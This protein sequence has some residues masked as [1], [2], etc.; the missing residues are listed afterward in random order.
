MSEVY[1]GVVFRS[2]ERAARRTFGSLSSGL[3][4][5]LVRLA[6]G[7]FGA[8]RVAGRAGALDQPAVERVAQ[9]VSAAVGRAVA[10]FYDNRCG[11]RAGVL[12]C[13]GRRDRELGDDDTWWARCGRDGEPIPGGRRFRITDLRPGEEYECTYSAIDAGLEVV[14]VGPRVSAAMVKQAFCYEELETL[15]EL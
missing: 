6:R 1:E 9:Q 3:R 2:A 11:I 12:Y 5:R 4:L 15:A 7:V 13:V 10:L 14:G 8:Y